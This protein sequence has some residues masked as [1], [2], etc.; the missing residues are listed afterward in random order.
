[1]LL[2]KSSVKPALISVR[3][4]SRVALTS[5]TLST[6]DDDVAATVAITID[7]DFEFDFRTLLLATITPS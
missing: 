7:E 2:R 4:A 3:G 6:T 5:A 1:M